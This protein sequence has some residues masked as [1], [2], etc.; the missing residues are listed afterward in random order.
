ME[1]DAD[2]EERLL[3]IV[4]ELARDIDEEYEEAGNY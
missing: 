1:G 2:K 3:D 4:D